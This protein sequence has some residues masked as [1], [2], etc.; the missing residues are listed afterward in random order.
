MVE[1]D[2]RPVR[3]HVT[4][5]AHVA[6]CDMGGRFSG[7]GRAVVA[8]RACACHVRMVEVNNRRPIAGHVTI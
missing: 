4:V 7:R 6:R 8:A 1:M 3:R 2:G 5:L